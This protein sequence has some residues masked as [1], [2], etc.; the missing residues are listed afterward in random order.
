M[1]IAVGVWTADLDP[2]E[3]QQRDRHG[4]CR[5]VMTVARAVQNDQVRG[6]L[7]MTALIVATHGSP[8]LSQPGE[9]TSA[10]T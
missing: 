3:I 5:W 6:S 9:D 4:P 1:I 2:E 10:A 7:T 8:Q